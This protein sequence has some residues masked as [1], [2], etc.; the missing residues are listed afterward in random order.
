M[1]KVGPWFNLKP[2]LTRNR[3]T[4]DKDLH[5]GIKW[6][7]TSFLMSVDTLTY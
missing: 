3:I 6:R 1:D 4:S 2:V 7:R 5:L